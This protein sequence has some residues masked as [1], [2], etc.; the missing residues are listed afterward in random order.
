MKPH[1]PHS[2]GRRTSCPSTQTSNGKCARKSKQPCRETSSTP[3]H[4]P[5]Q[6]RTSIS[7]QPWNPYRTLM[8]SAMRPYASTLQYRSHFAQP[9]GPQLSPTSRCLLAHASPYV[10]GQS[11]VHQRSG[12]LQLNSSS[13]SAGSTSTRRLVKQRSRTI[14]EACRAITLFRRSSM[15]HGVALGRVSPRQS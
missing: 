14:V 8:V 12:D 4:P 3:P 15:V 10:L 5:V 11:T 2:L 9:F 13:L 7:P 6:R 1:H